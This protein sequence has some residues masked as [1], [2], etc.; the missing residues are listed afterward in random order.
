MAEPRRRSW[1]D[2]WCVVQNWGF[3]S[4]IYDQIATKDDAVGIVQ[5]VIGS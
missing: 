1:V 4:G 2:G 3:S 5:G